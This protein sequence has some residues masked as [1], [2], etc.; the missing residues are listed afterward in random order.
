MEGKAAL[1]CCTRQENDFEYRFYK[2]RSLD[3]IRNSST[4]PQF[5]AEISPEQAQRVAA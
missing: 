3:L 5:L 4:L 1:V 2:A